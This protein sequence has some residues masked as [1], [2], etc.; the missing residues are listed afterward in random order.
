MLLF[1]YTESP[2]ATIINL[3]AWD[4]IKEENRIGVRKLYREGEWRRGKRS[5]EKETKRNKW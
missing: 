3:A 2:R 1:G 5:K 4:I